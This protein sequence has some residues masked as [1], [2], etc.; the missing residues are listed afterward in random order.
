MAQPFEETNSFLLVQVCRAHRNKANTLLSTVDLHAGQEF[1][2]RHLG[3]ND[4]M[5]QSD[6]AEHLCVQPATVT[7]MLDR[8]V[9][10]GLLERRKDDEDQRVSRVY[11]TDRGWAMQQSID[12][13]WQELESCSMAKFTT[14]EKILFR[15]LLMQMRDNLTE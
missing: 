10:A 12:D 11:L 15:R 5:T 8:M 1:V 2:I 6:L 4:G 7:K 3:R 9:S 14:D 13:V